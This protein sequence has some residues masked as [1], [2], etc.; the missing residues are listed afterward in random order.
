M[1]ILTSVGRRQL[2]SSA[3]G[4]VFNQIFGGPLRHIETPPITVGLPGLTQ[5]LNEEKHASGETVL[6]VKLLSWNLLAT[7]YVRSPT[8]ETEADGLS[9][10]RRQIAYVATQTDADVIG[11]QEFWYGSNA[12]VDLWKRFAEA[13]GYLLHVLPRVDGKQDGCAM[14]IRTARCKK[15]P[16]FSAFTYADWGSRVL[17]IAKI[18][19][20]GYDTPLVLMN[21]HLTFPHD[22]QHNSIMRKQQARKLSELVNEQHCSTVLFGDFN[23]PTKDDA[24]IQLITDIGGCRPHPPHAPPQSSSSKSSDKTEEEKKWYSHV[25]HTGALMSCDLVLTRGSCQVSEWSLGGTVEELVA[26]QLPSDHRPL[27]ATI[28]METS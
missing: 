5:R 11:L 23:N 25:A 20:D 16:E 2:F 22:T 17:Q 14:L 21:T 15:K 19:I 26:R 24:A 18:Q 6:P 1:Q 27:H 10:G 3:V 12:Y 9:R 7:P 28:V 8:K 4:I 13:N